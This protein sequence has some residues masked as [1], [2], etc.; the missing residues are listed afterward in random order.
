MPPLS[1]S[2]F[3]DSTGSQHTELLD[4]ARIAALTGLMEK[5]IW[6]S[7]RLLSRFIL[8]A[9]SRPTDLALEVT[10]KFLRESGIDSQAVGALAL[11]HTQYEGDATQQMAEEVADHV[12]VTRDRITAISFGCAGF[13]E[14]VKRAQ[15]MAEDIAPD[16]HVLVLNVE[17]PDQMM[18]A[19]D[20]R[21]TPIFASGASA[22]SLSHGRGHLLLFSETQD[23]VPPKNPN[24]VEIF[25]IGREEVEDF[26]GQRSEKT[27]FR[28][29]GELAY[30]NG[31]ALIEDAARRSLHHV[32][33][34][35]SF[36][37]RRVLVVPHQANAK[38]IRAFDDMIA[39]EMNRGEFAKYE[40]PEVRFVNG[41]EGM[42]NIISATIP[43]VLAR[44]P[45]MA[46]ISPKSGDVILFPAAGICI[47]D[48]GGKMSQ[49][50]GGMVWDP[51]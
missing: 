22:T 32:M 20:S 11:V 45:D 21:A 13:P 6:Q 50:L 5:R 27:I 23:V 36:H 14:I 39:P 34:D 43:S 42:G 16:Q 2:T 30:E 26:S 38:M 40:I 31:T 10:D 48:P 25:T 9:G 12:G 15:A 8:K 19:R 4:N 18:D 33:Q 37:G 51:R 46:D 44:L 3:V 17:T 7:T 28:M 41:M 49:G 47:A 35:S 1:F 29:E 24:G